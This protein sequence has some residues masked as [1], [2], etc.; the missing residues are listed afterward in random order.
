[1]TKQRTTGIVRRTLTQQFPW[2]LLFAAEIVIFAAVF[3][4]YQVETEAV[5]YA[6]G[7]CLL[8][9]IIFML[10]HI[11][12]ALRD[13]AKKQQLMD[14][15]VWDYRN[16]PTP[17]TLAEQDERDMLEML[18]GQVLELNEQI[19]E[20]QQESTDYYATWVHQ[21]KTPI[22]ALHMLLDEEDNEEH[23]AMAAELFRIEQYV[24]LVLE[25]HRLESS[26]EDLVL[27]E[28]PLDSMIRNVIHKLAR[29]IIRKRLRLEYTPTDL[30]VLTDEKWLS[31]ILEQLLANAIKYTN[32][33]SIRI[34][35]TEDQKIILEDTGIGIAPE[36]LP[37][38]FEQG[39]TGYNGRSGKKST[40]IGL[41][42][43]KRAADMLQVPISVRSKVGEGSAFTL[44]LGK[45]PLQIE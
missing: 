37:L 43:C 20:R 19:R 13:H 29:M 5:L 15:V 17:K 42:L 35:T 39:F 21:I 27:K 6:A 32:E 44:D 9:Q 28:Y 36:D 41:Y 23:R 14:T 11:I 22:A 18:V 16:L 34:Y 24:N 1:M 40:G 10:L 30:M 33:G 12:G 38:I 25:Y 8:L 3:S 7:I 45:K 26:T 31:F 2:L 4:L